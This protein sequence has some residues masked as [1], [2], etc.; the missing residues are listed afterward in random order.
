MRPERAKLTT[1]ALFIT[2]IFGTSTSS[3]LTT[4]FGERPH[5]HIRARRSKSFPAAPIREDQ[6]HTNSVENPTYLPGNMTNANTR[7][8]VEIFISLHH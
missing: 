3:R 5:P 1:S 8:N 4:N 6:L 7:P 2:G